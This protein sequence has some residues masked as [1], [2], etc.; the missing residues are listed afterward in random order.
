[1]KEIA[2]F[3]KT[4]R[5][6]AKLTQPELAERAGVGLRFIRELESNKETLRLDKVNAVLRL[7]GHTLGPVPLKRE[8]E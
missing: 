4:K 2:E 3:V 7:F 8:I 6:Q 5:K 1:M